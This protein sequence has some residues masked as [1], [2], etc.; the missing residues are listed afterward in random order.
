MYQYSLTWFINLYTQSIANSE[1]SND[2]QER[3][4]NLNNHF[5]LSIYNNVCRSLFEKDKLLFSLL[6][7]I[8][9][10]KGRKEVDDESWRFLLTGGVALDNPHPNP[11]PSWLSDKSWGEIVRASDLPELKGLMNGKREKEKERERGR[12]KE[13]IKKYMCTCYYVWYHLCVLFRFQ[14]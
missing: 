10:L 3:I 2:L 11:F 1:K 8:G 7:C 13:D 14:S 9:V 6:L 5:T 12:E 4:G